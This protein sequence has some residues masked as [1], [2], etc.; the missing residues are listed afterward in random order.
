MSSNDPIAVGVDVGADRLHLVCLSEGYVL[1]GTAVLNPVDTVRVDDWFAALPAG[2]V[3]AV[4]GPPA[5]SAA[6]FADDP[7][8]S[9]KFRLAR[10][11]EVE[12]G[13]QRGVWV[14]FATGPAPL[15]GWMAE[16]ARVHDIG[17]AFG[18]VTLET[19]PHAV[20]RTLLGSRPAKKSTADGT[21]QRVEALRRMGL[22][23]DSM[24]MWSHDS[25]DAAAAA[26][27]ARQHIDGIA[28]AITCD[29]DGSSIWLPRDNNTYA[30]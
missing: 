16:A 10:G 15:T 12:L 2:S 25:L 20:F 23:L 4:D 9:A 11:C 26:V 30:R 5:P 8:V 13:R 28:E 6:P 14:S 22:H 3:I 27:V 1:V 29:A 7:T 21:N 19:Y 18:H 17:A 24:P